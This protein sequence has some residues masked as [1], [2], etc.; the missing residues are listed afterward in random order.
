MPSSGAFNSSLLATSSNSLRRTRGRFRGPSKHRVGGGGGGGLQ[1]FELTTLFRQQEAA[2]L[3]VLEEVRWGRLTPEGNATLKRRVAEQ[4]QRTAMR[5]L[6]RRDDANNQAFKAHSGAEHVCVSGTMRL[7]FPPLT[8]VVPT[9][10][11][12]CVRPTCSLQRSH[13]ACALCASVTW[14]A[15]GTR[16]TSGARAPLSALELWFCCGEE[17]SVRPWR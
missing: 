17:C 4:R 16:R 13:T 7:L 15:T 6:A 14:F 10:D 5:V 12:G 9:T 8:R 11:T 2:L 3:A 1:H